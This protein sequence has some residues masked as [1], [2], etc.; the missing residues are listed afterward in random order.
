MATE[1]TKV[2]FII[3]SFF[4]NYG[5]SSEKNNFMVS[6]YEVKKGLVLMDEEIKGMSYKKSD[7]ELVVKELTFDDVQELNSIIQNTRF[8]HKNSDLGTCDING[9]FKFNDKLIYFVCGTAQIVISTEETRETILL[10]EEGN[11]KL[12]RLITAIK[13]R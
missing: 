11:H 13:T 5:C 1:M 6:Y 2:L 4:L 7:Y 10:T 3:L 8:H 9:F 12:N